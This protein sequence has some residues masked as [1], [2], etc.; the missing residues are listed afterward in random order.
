MRK[1]TQTAIS[2]RPV[3][4]KNTEKMLDQVTYF[5]PFCKF[6]VQSS[7]YPEIQERFNIW[8]IVT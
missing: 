6:M 4:Y 1:I 2:Q 8:A 3:N 7:K 5:T